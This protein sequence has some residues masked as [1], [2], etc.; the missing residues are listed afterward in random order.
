MSDQNALWD[1]HHWRGTASDFHH[2]S[3]EFRRAMWWCSVTQ[4]AL[5]LGSTQKDNV[6]DHDSAARAGIEV[7]QRRSGGGL[8][9][10]HPDN[11]IWIDIT[12]SR[13]DAL[14]NDD[15]SRSML[16]LGDVWSAALAPWI[17]TASHR[18]QFDAGRDGQTVCFASTSPGEVFR[19]DAK[20]VGIS[21][22]RTRDGARFQC[23]VYRRWEPG[24]WVHCLA[25][26][27]LAER[28]CALPVAC[29]DAPSV[30]IV[31]AV[32]AQL[33]LL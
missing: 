18:G 8:V 9:Y 4:P 20:V 27:N 15:V 32:R 12:I 23:V 30:A 2:E 22:R 5:I 24:Q 17:S 28:V 21:Q 10:V 33:G 1:L 3:L 6:V 26:T 31:E 29:V 7:A 25:D 19:N 16:W 11:S 13:D 14:W